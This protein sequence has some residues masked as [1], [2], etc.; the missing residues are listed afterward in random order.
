MCARLHVN[1]CVCVCT[2]CMCVCVSQWWL[3]VQ[4]QIWLTDGLKSNPGHRLRGNSHNH[5]SSPFHARTPPREPPPHL[6]PS[7]VLP[8]IQRSVH[9]ILCETR[10]R[11]KFN[12]SR[13]FSLFWSINSTHVHAQTHT[14]SIP[15]PFEK[16]S[17]THQLPQ[18][19]SNSCLRGSTSSS[20]K[21]AK[22]DPKT[23]P[24]SLTFFFLPISPPS[25]S[26]IPPALPLCLFPSLTKSKEAELDV[27]SSERDTVPQEASTDPE[28]PRSPPAEANGPTGIVCSN[29]PCSSYGNGSPAGSRKTSGLGDIS[30]VSSRAE[31]AGE[32]S[33]QFSTRPPSAEQPG[34]MG[35]WQQQSTDSNLLYRMSQQVRQL[36]FT[37]LILFTSPPCSASLFPLTFKVSTFFY[38]F[39]FFFNLAFNLSCACFD[40]GTFC[41]WVRVK[42]C[43][44]TVCQV[45]QD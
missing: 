23:I 34:F 45:C 25:H 20:Q 41:F 31:G 27:R 24:P 1:M 44:W 9:L 3:H 4:V 26:H 7:L 18:L 43:V 28:P 32:S 39:F 40:I 37:P 5:P 42:R 21:A 17:H 19:L 6:H 14:P 33:M 2:V 29:A 15:G 8:H 13:L 38:S 10:S 36:I 16:A 22:R 35:T 12:A 30:I 11:R